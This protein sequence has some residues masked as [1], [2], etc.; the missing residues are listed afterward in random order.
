[1]SLQVGVDDHGFVEHPAPVRP[2]V[3]ALDLVQPRDLFQAQDVLKALLEVVRQ[4]GIQDGVGAAVGIAEHHHKVEGAL[5]DG[6]GLYR[7]GDGGDVEDVEGQPA[8]NE[9]RHHNG[10]HPS[11]LTL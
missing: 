3:A 9:Y 7:A 1:M 10:H 6:G 5:H 2:A 8:Q 4:E 11:H